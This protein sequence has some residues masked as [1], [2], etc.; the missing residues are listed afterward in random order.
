MVKV[1]EYLGSFKKTNKK[2]PVL[3]SERYRID[4]NSHPVCYNLVDL[5]NDISYRLRFKESQKDDEFYYAQEIIDQS[6]NQYIYYK[7]AFSHYSIINTQTKEEWT[8]PS[9]EKCKELC[10]ELNSINNSYLNLKGCNKKRRKLDRDNKQLAKKI[11]EISNVVA[12]LT[13]CPDLTDGEM[14]ILDKIA[15]VVFK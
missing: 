5:K 13:E 12:D 6:D 1:S 8:I 14:Q 2:I 4:D 10:A 3:D 9:K 7:S 11:L 15:R